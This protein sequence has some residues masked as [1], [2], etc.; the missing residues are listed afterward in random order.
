MGNRLK[1]LREKASMTQE[2]LAI[3]A[4]VSRQTII[5]LEKGK[6]NPSIT[7]AYKLSRIF[8]VSIEELF[9][10][11]EMEEKINE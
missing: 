6:Y 9:R 7:L 11:K 1:E 5:S 3:R 10:L 2:D 4:Q 8:G